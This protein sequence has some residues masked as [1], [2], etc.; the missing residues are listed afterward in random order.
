M[1][2]IIA[3]AWK[4]SDQSR[5]MKFIQDANEQEKRIRIRWVWLDAP[6]NDQFHPF[7]DR[8]QLDPVAEGKEMFFMKREPEG[9]G[10]FHTYV[11]VKVND[12]WSGALELSESLSDLD[13][14]IRTTLFQIS[15][16]IIV[17]IF[18]SGL[19][20]IFLGFKLVG[21]PLQLL[22]ERARRIGQGDLWEKLHL[23]SGDELSELAETLN[24]MCEDLLEYRK[25]L[26]LETESRIAAIEQLRHAD[27]L[28]T[29]GKLASGIA[30][31]LGTP[32]N[33]IDGNAT[34]MIRGILNSEEILESA[35]VIKTQSKRMTNIIQQLLNFARRHT[36]QKKLVDLCQII[37]QTLSLLE[38]FGRKHKAVFSF[39]DKEVPFTAMV[40]TDQ[41]QQILIN[42]ITNGIQA[43]P[44]GGKLELDIY[45][46]IVQP[47]VDH[48][49]NEGEYLCIE[50]RDEGEGIIE[51]DKSR[52]FEPF[53][54]TKDI[55]QGTGLGLSIVHGLVQEHEGWIEIESKPGEGS[56]IFVYLP[57]GIEE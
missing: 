40:D 22:T 13:Q 43:M 25:K 4:S 3:D 9:K 46:K 38:S 29:V 24:I 37:H 32:L 18:I 30:H 14:Y 39:V 15:I 42:L 26:S 12:K 56:S 51:E 16:L 1:R 28:R 50:V 17:M 7:I 48:G 23:Q 10:N 53:Y 6:P 55:G 8:S 27:R 54:T 47:P 44:D 36:H 52:L 2:G 20:A 11:P 21:K 45:R 34:L 5:V 49:K 31:E 41:I 19:L 57:Q 33:V 35:T